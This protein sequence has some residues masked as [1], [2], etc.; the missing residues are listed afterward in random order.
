M[1]PLKV[2][3]FRHLGVDIDGSNDTYEEIN[4][5]VVYGPS[6]NVEFHSYEKIKNQELH[7]LYNQ[8]NIIL[9]I[10]RGLDKIGRSIGKISIGYS[11]NK[12]KTTVRK[13]Q[14]PTVE[15]VQDVRNTLHLSGKELL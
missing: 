4:E 6:Y 15:Y 10:R 3:V 5:R 9:Y 2:R 13:T 8:P 14:H 11:R 1:N 12:Q 7:E